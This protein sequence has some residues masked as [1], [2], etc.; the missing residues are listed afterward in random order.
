MEIV[1]GIATHGR[2]AILAE[3]LAFLGLQKRMPDRILVV[4]A[5]LAD[6]GGCPEQF[7]QV[8]FIA[9]ELGL[10]RQRNVIVD[11]AKDCDLLQFFDDDF[12]P[13]PRYLEI[14]EKVPGGASGG[15]GD[16]RPGA[17]G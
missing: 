17:G 12:Y 15:G 10:T 6:V 8:T 5:D 4:Y 13:D 16:D 2:S 3:T 14:T 7:P 9:A 11:M 1:V